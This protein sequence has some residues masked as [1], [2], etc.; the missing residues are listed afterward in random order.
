MPYTHIP[1][2]AE[3]HGISTPESVFI[4]SM[5]GPY[6][7]ILLLLIMKP[8]ILFYFV[9]NLYMVLRCVVSVGVASAAGRISLG[10]LSD[11]FGKLRMLRICMLGGGVSVLSWLSCTTFSSI[12]AF[13]VCFGFFA[14]G[15]ISLIPSVCAEMFGVGSIASIIGEF[16][17]HWPGLDEGSLRDERLFISVVC[18]K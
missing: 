1:I 4:L 9:D 16:V 18:C 10:Y 11:F 13:S 17:K 15:V 3:Q 12:M 8:F 6:T 2:Y 5:I 7:R 14:G